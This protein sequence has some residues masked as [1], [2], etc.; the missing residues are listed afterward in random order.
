MNNKNEITIEAI[1]EK[2]AKLIL[3]QIE[4]KKDNNTSPFK[5]TGKVLKSRPLATNNI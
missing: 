2:W 1:A 4:N 5:V 3:T